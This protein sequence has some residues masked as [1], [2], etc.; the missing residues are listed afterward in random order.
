MNFGFEPLK[1]IPLLGDTICEFHIKNGRNRMRVNLEGR[2]H[3]NLPAKKI[4]NF[5]HPALARAIMSIGF[6]G[7]L[8]LESPIISDDPLEDV[9]DNLAYVREVYGILET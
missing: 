6:R 1:E 7:W 5:N 9:R 4:E 3:P 8:I 2:A